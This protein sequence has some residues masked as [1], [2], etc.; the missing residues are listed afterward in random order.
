MKNR[1]EKVT[2]KRKTNPFSNYHFHPFEISFCGYSNSGKTTLL[3]KI[4]NRLSK[5]YKVAYIK[6]D[7]HKFD[8]D[9][10]GKD[11]YIAWQAGAGEVNISDQHHSAYLTR[12][13]DDLAR[14]KKTFL[15]SDIVLI[16]GYKS[17]SIPKVL[18]LDKDHLILKKYRDG[19]VDSV[20]GFIGFGPRPKDIPHD[21]AYFDIND[22]D[23]ITQF[24]MDYLKQKSNS[25]PLKGLILTGGKST[26]MKTDKALINY[27]GKSQIEHCYDLLKTQCNEVFVSSQENQWSPEATKHIPLLFDEFI[28]LGPMGGI[29][30][31]MKKY[32]QTA[33]LVLAVDLPYVNKETLADLI[34]NRDPFKMSTCYKSHSFK[35]GVEPLCAIYEPKIYSHLFDYLGLGYSCPR[36]ALMNAEIQQVEL[37]NNSALDNVNH[38]DERQRALKIMEQGGIL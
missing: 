23:N 30:T 1:E 6:H 16:E 25:I 32:P 3:E 24:V 10:P 17:L 31:A 11:T 21:G 36:K 34:E 12:N 2:T 13:T 4:I 14:Q 26:R 29:L 33:W 27:H 7:A 9:K 8:M 20:I 22:I 35:G 18:I 15:N 38:P 19:E 28:N 5:T 37:K